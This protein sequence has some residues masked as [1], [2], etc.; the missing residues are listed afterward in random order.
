MLPR[1]CHLKHVIERRIE[2]RMRVRGRRGRRRKK[3]LANLKETRGH[4]KLIA[5]SVENLLWEMLWTCLKT[6]YK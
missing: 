3:L 5:L 2:G 6:Y 1:N 4:R